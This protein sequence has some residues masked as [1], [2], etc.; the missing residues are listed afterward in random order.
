MW[1]YFMNVLLDPIKRWHRD[2]LFFNKKKLSNTFF[3]FTFGIK[4]TKRT[5]DISVLHSTFYTLVSFFTPL[6]A[7]HYWTEQDKGVYLLNL[8]TYSYKQ[9]YSTS[10]IYIWLIVTSRTIYPFELWI[11]VACKAEY[12]VWY[13]NSMAWWR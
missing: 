11:L 8:F 10:T 5:M 13:C 2:I 4:E 3:T 6:K 7:T 1:F 12:M 9:K